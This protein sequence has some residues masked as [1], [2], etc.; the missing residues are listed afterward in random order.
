MIAVWHFDRAGKP[1]DEDR[2]GRLLEDDTYKRVA[3]GELLVGVDELTGDPGTSM[4]VSTVWL[5]LNHAF[6]DNGPLQIFE[7]MIFGGPYDGELMRYGTEEDALDGHRRVMEDLADGRPP[8]WTEA[9]DM[10]PNRAGKHR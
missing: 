5:G 7:T 2:W 8:W 3:L 10:P 1:I 6:F 4:K 9:D